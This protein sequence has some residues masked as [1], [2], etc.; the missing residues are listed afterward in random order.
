[1][2]QPDATIAV[3]VETP[4][5]LVEAS[6]SS[7]AVAALAGN[8]AGQVEQLTAQVQALEERVT[9][10]EAEAQAA[11][12]A[13][14]AAAALAATPPPVVAV[15]PVA[16]VEEVTPPPPPKAEPPAA[17]PKPATKRHPLHRMIFG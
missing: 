3:T 8:A 16:A 5:P 10:A 11:A 2:S 9:Q 14:A 7:V 4:P 12:D 13:A 1:M 17:E 6:P 15:E